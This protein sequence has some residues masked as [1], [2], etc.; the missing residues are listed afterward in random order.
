MSVGEDATANE[1]KRDGMKGYITNT[2]LDAGEIVAKY[3][4]LWY[5]ERAFRIK[6][7]NL[8]AKPLFHFTEKRIV[9]YICVFFIAHKVYKKLQRIIS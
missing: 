7:G 8:E 9:A 2:D 4:S 5:V 6:K 1:A 3:H